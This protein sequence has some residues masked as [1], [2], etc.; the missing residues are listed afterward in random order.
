MEHDIRGGSDTMYSRSLSG[1][2][3][4]DTGIEC[5]CKIHVPEQYSGNRFSKIKSDKEDIVRDNFANVKIPEPENSTPVFNNINNNETEMPEEHSGDYKEPPD[6]QPSGENLP[7]VSVL[8]Q[9][10]NNGNNYDNDNF[11]EESS[12]TSVLPVKSE[13]ERETNQKSILSGFSTEDLLLMGLILILLQ[14]GKNN[15]DIVILLALL[16]VYH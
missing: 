4:G 6:I 13:K 11:S 16:L 14:D 5:G 1:R 12:E 8:N 2:Y 3:L 9:N 7:D 10:E 15:E